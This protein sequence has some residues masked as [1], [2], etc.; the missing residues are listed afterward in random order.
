MIW[1]EKKYSDGF[2]LLCLPPTRSQLRQKPVTIAAVV[3]SGVPFIPRRGSCH[4]DAGAP[5]PR[6]RPRTFSVSESF[7]TFRL[8]I[9][10]AKKVSLCS[11]YECLL[12]QTC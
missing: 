7:L 10:P 3:A 11:F 2:I 9:I 6:R 5:R 1:R 8:G 4:Q 12:L